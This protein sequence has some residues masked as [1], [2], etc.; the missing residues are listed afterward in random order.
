MHA[1]LFVAA[2]PWPVEVALPISSDIKNVNQLGR[3][4]QA[5]SRLQF[6]GWVLP[7]LTTIPAFRTE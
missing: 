7:W 6:G 3:F 4:L 5:S 2:E 1:S